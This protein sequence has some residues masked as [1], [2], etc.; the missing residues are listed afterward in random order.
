MTKI[1][2]LNKLETQ[3]F[4]GLRVHLQEAAINAKTDDEREL[5]SSMLRRVLYRQTGNRDFIERGRRPE[6]VA[7]EPTAALE[8]TAIEPSA[9]E[10]RVSQLENVCGFWLGHNVAA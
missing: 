6:P 9:L 3:K 8:A 10:V 5:A 1:S 2:N 4:E 7:I